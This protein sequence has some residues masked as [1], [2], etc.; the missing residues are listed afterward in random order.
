MSFPALSWAVRQRLP[1]TQKLV[2]LMLAERHNKDSGQCNPSLELLAEDCGLSRRSVI[3]QIAKLQTAGYLT[4]RH[5]AN[6]GLRLPSQYVLHMGFGVPERIQT[7]N[8]DPYLLPPKVVNNVHSGSEPAAPSSERASPPQCNTFTTPVNDVHQG[9]EPAAHKPGNEPGIEPVNTKRTSALTIPGV[10][11]ELVSEWKAVRKEKRAGPIS[12][13]VID[14]LYREAGK[15]GIT[16]ED[17]VRHCVERGW[18]G[19]KADWY[20]KDQGQPAGAATT[21]SKYAGAA[22]AIWGAPSAQ[23]RAGVI[24]V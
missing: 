15:A 23:K 4:V 8:F 17:A 19:F 12:Q 2:L 9:S 22:A 10:S 18:Q 11:D 13:T 20:L 14:A 24:D 6:E 21:P 7:E 5:R 3:D 16:P 1:S